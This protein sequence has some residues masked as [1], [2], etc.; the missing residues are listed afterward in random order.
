MSATLLD[1]ALEQLG[2][3]WSALVSLKAAVLGRHVPSAPGLYRIRRVGLPFWDYAGETGTGQM[4]LRRRMAML[5]GV[6]LPEM[7]YRDPHTAGPGFWALLQTSPQPLEAEFCPIEGSPSWRKGLEAAAIAL[8]RQEH[9]RSPTFNFGRIPLGFRIS[10]GNNARL[11]AAGKR[12]R[13]GRDDT[14]TQSHEPGLPPIGPLGSDIPSARWCGHTWT[15]WM[16]FDTRTIQALPS[17]DGLYRIRGNNQRLVYI[18]E[19][20][21]R[22]RLFAHLA[23]LDASTDQGRALH[24]AAPLTFSAALNSTRHRH[25]R[26]ELEIDLI[27][28]YVLAA[29]EPPAA[30]FVG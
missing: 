9:Q 14:V 26:L 22:S 23:K 19:G 15:A 28:A 27:G 13:G 16:T 8:H 3:R 25:Q 4:T 20:A 1:H 21:I 7:P 18:G 30:Q 6:Y 12:L 10:W 24:D 17:E 29:H 11:V 5:R 2:A